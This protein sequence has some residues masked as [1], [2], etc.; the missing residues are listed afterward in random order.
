MKINFFD[1]IV[2]SIIT[3]ALVFFYIGFYYPD[4]M[5]FNGFVL[6]L[7]L[8]A[9]RF[10][11][12]FL[13]IGV[14]WVYIGLRNGKINK[15]SVILTVI[16]VVFSLIIVLHVGLIRYS[17]KNYMADKTSQFHPFL[18]LMPNLIDTAALRE[19]STNRIA[20]MG[21][22]TTA[23]KKKKGGGGTGH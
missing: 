18:Q 10:V 3:I 9:I 5:I 7:L 8:Y 19:H 6:K 13:I 1:I 16:S 15:S 20:C 11:F 21:G 17:L 4:E 14:L 22:V 12:P 2:L 23:F